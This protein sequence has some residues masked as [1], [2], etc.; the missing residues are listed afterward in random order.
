MIQRYLWMVSDIS[1]VL[2]NTD[3][4]GVPVRKINGPL[5]DLWK[6]M[7]KS[8]HQHPNNQR[9]ESS[10]ERVEFESGPWI[11]M[12]RFMDW[13]VTE[14]QI[15]GGLDLSKL[16]IN[17]EQ[18]ATG[19]HTSGTVKEDFLV[20]IKSSKYVDDEIVA[21]FHDP[22]GCIDGYFHRDVVE[23]IG[24]ALVVGTGLILRNVTVFVP[25]ERRQQYLNICRGNVIEE[26]T[27]F[28]SEQPTWVDSLSILED[29]EGPTTTTAD[30]LAMTQRQVIIQ[31]HAQRAPPKRKWAWKSF[32][33]KKKKTQQQEAEPSPTTSESP[34]PAKL[35]TPPSAKP[36]TLKSR[37]PART[38]IAM[39]K[40]SVVINDTPPSS[41]SRAK[42]PTIPS[43]RAVI[44]SGTPSTPTPAPAQSSRPTT[45]PSNPISSSLAKPKAVLAKPGVSNATSAAQIIKPSMAPDEVTKAIDDVLNEDDW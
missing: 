8:V 32:A 3:L 31:S 14:G 13:G 12:C 7:S 15:N 5:S 17:T 25:V 10:E 9:M 4:T 42:P 33:P 21:T 18:I 19:F 27:A 6:K 36:S 41:S 30:L 43:P 28:N 24:A 2:L 39:T 40:K 34:S 1:V 35:P 26:V 44:P 16:P 20:L 45:A 11:E 23:A 37:S 38:P 29:P 22:L